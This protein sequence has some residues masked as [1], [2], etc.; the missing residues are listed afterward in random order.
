MFSLSTCLSDGRS[1]NLSND[2][3]VRVWQ[4]DVE[5]K[6]CVGTFKGN[7][8]DS[9]LCA[10]V[11]LQND[12]IV[13]GY[14]DGEMEIWDVRGKVPHFMTNNMSLKKPLTAL[15]ALSDGRFVS[16]HLNRNLQVC[17]PFLSESLPPLVIQLT[18][19]A[20]VTALAALP[21]SVLVTAYN[22]CKMEVWDLSPEKTFTS[23]FSL[24]ENVQQVSALT[25]LN[26]SGYLVGLCENK[27]LQI[28]KIHDHFAES[29]IEL[30]QYAAASPCLSVLSKKD[31]EQLQRWCTGAVTRRRSFLPAFWTNDSLPSSFPRVDVQKTR[32]ELGEGGFGTV[33]EAKIVSKNEP[34]ALK[35]ARFQQGEEN[36]ERLRAEILLHIELSHPNILSLYGVARTIANALVMECMR[37]D[38]WLLYIRNSTALLPWLKRLEIALDVAEGLVYLHGLGIIHRDIKGENI[39]LNGNNRAKISDFGLSRKRDPDVPQGIVGFSGTHDWMAPE[40]FQNYEIAE[41]LNGMLVG[42]SKSVDQEADVYCNE[43]TDVYALGK[44]FEE[45]ANRNELYSKHFLM[46]GVQGWDGTSSVH[47]QVIFE[48]LVVKKLENQHMP[49]AE[50]TPSDYAALIDQTRNPDNA[51]RV[52]LSVIVEELKRQRKQLHRTCKIDAR[53]LQSQLTQLRRK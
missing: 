53:D 27:H 25:V 18:T 7:H 16:S 8:K 31:Q 17:T 26:E 39:L 46:E 13:L 3:F 12:C 22:E 36:T 41:K 34:V 2:G 37:G 15:V 30:T 28:W 6:T 19:N 5:S 32:E 40:L 44:F 4:V 52:A 45:V 51:S 11:S 9:D 29:V 20:P 42:V 50:D 43:S 33:Y 24:Q 48:R 21:N 38:F 23:K 47:P 35:I 49:L 10:I 1:V 14:Q